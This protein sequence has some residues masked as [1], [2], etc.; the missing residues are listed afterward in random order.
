MIELKNCGFKNVCL[1]CAKK[2]YKN[3]LPSKYL[4]DYLRR[5]AKHRPTR[6][7]SAC[8]ENRT[9]FYHTTETVD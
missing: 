6:K 1:E 3:S 7:C 5:S 4:E 2:Y 8:L 9:V